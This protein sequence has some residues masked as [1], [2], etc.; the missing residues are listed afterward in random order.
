MPVFCWGVLP[1]PKVS[2]LRPQELA[3]I[4]SSLQ[5]LKMHCPGITSEDVTKSDLLAELT[6]V[7]SDGVAENL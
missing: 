1:K 3:F 5:Q 7:M 6:D 2:V 4:C